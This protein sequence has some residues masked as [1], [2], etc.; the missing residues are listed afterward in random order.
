MKVNENQILRMFD[1]LRETL[2]SEHAV[3][4][5]L[6][7]KSLLDQIKNQQDKKLFDTNKTLLSSK[8]R[9]AIDGD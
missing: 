5:K 3:E 7:I 9:I 8:R 6:K 1:L 4:H 2:S